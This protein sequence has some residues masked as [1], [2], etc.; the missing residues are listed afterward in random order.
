MGPLAA[1]LNQMEQ[2]NQDQQQQQEQQE[3][4]Y[5]SANRFTDTGKG[6]RRIEA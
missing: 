2:H 3:D 5:W 4:L 6:P 1:L